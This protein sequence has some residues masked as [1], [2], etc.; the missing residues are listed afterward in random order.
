MFTPILRA[1]KKFFPTCKITFLCKNIHKEVLS[2]LPYV[3]KVVCIY[4]GK[5]FGR[6]RAIPDLFGQD[7]I[8]FTDWHTV[9]LIFAKIFQIPMRI[10]YFREESFLTK[11]LTKELRGNIFDSIDYAACTN[12]K[13]I[14]DA[15]EIEI[16]DDMTNIEISPPTSQ[17]IQSV[18]KILK[19]IGLDKNC[20]FILLTPYTGFEPRNLPTE[21]MKNFIVLVEENFKIPVI[22]SAPPEKFKDAKIF[23]KYALNIETSIG[24]F[25]ELVNR[26]KILVTPDSG[27]MHV[28]GA[29][30]KN[31]VAIFSKDLPSRWAPKKNC[32]P[33]YLNLPCSPCDDETAKKCSHLSCIKNISAQMIFAACEKFLRISTK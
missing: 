27:P 17:E 8:I 24:E 33:L 31:C 18:D 3:D 1:I 19:N 25:V 21:I 26:S 2:R 14:C 5:I 20:E 7:I 11:F 29:L 15:L 10:G 9:P 30:Q 13:I 16:D 23:S 28:A 12:A 4:R 6:Y 22:I 32:L